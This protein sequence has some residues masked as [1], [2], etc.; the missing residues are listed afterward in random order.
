[1]SRPK[2]TPKTGGRE[3]GTPN[4]AT[5]SMRQWIQKVIDDNRELLEADIKKMEPRDRW[6]LVEKLIQYNT[7][8]MRES[9]LRIDLATLSD[10]DMDRIIDEL[11]GGTENE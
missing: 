11:M 10:A 6:L 2:G 3:A 9:D 4:K 5:A 7:P 1:M 8:K